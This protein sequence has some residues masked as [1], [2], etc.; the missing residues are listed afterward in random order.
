MKLHR[1][2]FIAV[3]IFYVCIVGMSFFKWDSREIAITNFGEYL[4]IDE[5][6]IDGVRLD[7]TGCDTLGSMESYT[8][9]APRFSFVQI[10]L[11]RSEQSGEVQIATPIKTRSLNLFGKDE[12]V[13][14]HPRTTTHV[15]KILMA[16]GLCI[17]FGILFYL[18]R[19]IPA[20]LSA[21]NF[22]WILLSALAS[23]MYWCRYFPKIYYVGADTWSYADFFSNFPFLADMRTPV[24]PVFLRACEFIARDRAGGFT[25]A[26]ILQMVTGLVTIWLFYRI[27]KFITKSLVAELV[28]L[29]FANLPMILFFEH[30]IMTESLGLFFFLA[31]VRLVQLYLNKPSA[32]HAI[33]IAVVMVFCIMQRPGFLYLLPLLGLFYIL[34]GVTEKQIKIAARAV[35]TLVVPVIAVVGLCFYNYRNVGRFEISFVPVLHN[36]GFNLTDRNIYDGTGNRDLEDLITQCKYEYGNNHWFYVNEIIDRYYETGYEEF[37]KNAKKANREEVI[38]MIAE[39]IRNS[40]WEPM[41]QDNISTN[42]EKY[43]NEGASYMQEG[44][45]WIEKMGNMV[46]FPFTYCIVL[47]TCV[48]G[49]V[50]RLIHWVMTKKAAWFELGMYSIVIATFLS[51]WASGYNDFQR[52]TISC[53]PVVYILI[54]VIFETVARSK[55]QSV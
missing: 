32:G 20:K 43:L 27:C 39:R 17:L 55:K 23:R 4:Q 53:I 19:W 10:G 2:I 3:I 30:E 33:G 8:F 52:L 29:L 37:L 41:V 51:S 26:A 7:L 9:T 48:G 25:M 24:Y 45:L 49:L 13:Y 28:T 40:L 21:C 31:E 44:G 18:V 6:S 16:A 11:M 34:H 1:R 15:E 5:I 12:I 36:D 35:V 38:Y 22:A 54:V 50:A 14:L 46:M 42:R 47:F